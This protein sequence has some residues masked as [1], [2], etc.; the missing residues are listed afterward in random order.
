MVVAMG[1]RCIRDASVSRT[2]LELFSRAWWVHKPIDA[3]CHHCD[4]QNGWRNIPQPLGGE[5]TLQVGN[6]ALEYR[7]SREPTGRTTEEPSLGQSPPTMINI[8]PQLSAIQHAVK[9]QLH[10][11]AHSEPPPS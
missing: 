9:T 8:R 4:G 11:C 5:G 7:A 1:R 2:H 3:Q 10:H 6:I